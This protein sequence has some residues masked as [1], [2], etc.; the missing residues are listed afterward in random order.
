MSIAILCTGVGFCALANATSAAPTSEE[1]NMVKSASLRWLQQRG[2]LFKQGGARRL[3]RTPSP[4]WPGFADFPSCA[5]PV[6]N[7]PI[8]VDVASRWGSKAGKLWTLRYKVGRTCTSTADQA[9]E[10]VC[11]VSLSVLLQAYHHNTDDH[12]ECEINC[13]IYCTVDFSI[14]I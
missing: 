6:Y 1:T 4:S 11:K 12:N 14:A 13:L 5:C 9:G 8:Q 2:S 10:Q 3:C 7:R